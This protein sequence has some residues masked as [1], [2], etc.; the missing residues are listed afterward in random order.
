VVV[1]ASVAVEYLVTLSLT[2]EAQALFRGVVERDLELW[3]PD[4]LCAGALSALRKLLRVRAITA[5]EAQTS[6]GRLIRLP[7]IATGTAP[8]LPRAWE[9]RDRVTPYDGR[10]VAL[11]E[12]LNAPF[13]TAERRLVSALPRDAVEALFLGDLR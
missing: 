2:R 5:S 13:V 10:Y 4:L 9:L 11:A 12:K 8:F 6:L 1:D 3:A 7:F